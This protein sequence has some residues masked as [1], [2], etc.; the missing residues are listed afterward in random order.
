MAGREQVVGRY[1]TS[2]TSATYP[3][4]FVAHVAH[5]AHPGRRGQKTFPNTVS[6]DG[7]N[8]EGDR[9]KRGSSVPF[10]HLS[11]PFGHPSVP[12]QLVNAR[13]R[14]SREAPKDRISEPPGFPRLSSRRTSEAHRGSR[15]RIRESCLRGESSGRDEGSSER[16][17]SRAPR[18]R[19][20]RRTRNASRSNFDRPRVR[21]G[22]RR[23]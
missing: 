19:P 9:H 3:Y 13:F 8:R 16:R 15:R 10:A 1:A 12:K 17:P 21:T 6:G 23:T 20:D 4:G 11:V 5:V 18:Q 14:A 22:T 7:T 2:A